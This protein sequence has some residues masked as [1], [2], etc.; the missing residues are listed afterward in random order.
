MTPRSPQFDRAMRWGRLCGLLGM[1]CMAPFSCLANDLKVL[2]VL[3]DGS[4]P[5]QAFANAYEQSSAGANVTVLDHAEDFSDGQQSDLIVAVGVKAAA[6]VSARTAKPVLAAML[7]SNRYAELSAKRPRGGQLSAIFVDQPWARQVKLLRAVL[8]ERKKIGLLHSLDPHFDLNALRNLLTERGGVLN[9]HAIDSSGNLF[10]DL[11]RV[12]SSSD[13]LLAVP[14]NVIYNS[15]TIRNILLSSYRRK[16]PLVGLSPA[17]VNAGALYAV[18]STPEQL[19]A[20]AAVA[21]RLFG[22]TKH[23]PNPEFP[24]Q[25]TIAVNR[26]VARMLGIP[27]KPTGQL[28]LEVEQQEAKR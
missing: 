1:L 23:L 5:Y 6:W 25:F 11:E 8:P 17:Y 27:V 16:V 4:E 3:S 26:E 19:A 21:V 12:L 7:P 22:Q 10:D 13:V 14:D 20:Q 18:Y 28:Q 24:E 2:L 15:G 9:A